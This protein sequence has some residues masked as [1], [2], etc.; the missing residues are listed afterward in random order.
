MINHVSF[1]QIVC[2]ASVLRIPKEKLFWTNET[3]ESTHVIE[4]SNG[5]ALL[6][7]K[8]KCNFKT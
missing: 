2:E 5:I 1:V 7:N 8:Y 3:R 4:L 6:V